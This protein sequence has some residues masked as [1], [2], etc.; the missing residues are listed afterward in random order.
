MYGHTVFSHSIRK[1]KTFAIDSGM[2]HSKGYVMAH[3]HTSEIGSPQTIGKRK[4]ILVIH[5]FWNG[6]SFRNKGINKEEIQVLK[7]RKALSRDT[8]ICIRSKTNSCFSVTDYKAISLCRRM[9]NR[10]QCYLNPSGIKRFEGVLTKGLK[11]KKFEDFSAICDN[12]R[13]AV[14]SRHF[15]NPVELPK[16]HEVIKMAMSPDHVIDMGGAMGEELLAEVGSCFNEGVLV[17]FFDEDGC[18]QPLY[19]FRAGKAAL[20]A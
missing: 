19:S 6:I 12:S 9:I 11:T 10:D 20:G 7:Q 4:G 13:P 18:S 1:M 16:A 15:L 3:V 17:F 2:R 14:N 5:M 8:G